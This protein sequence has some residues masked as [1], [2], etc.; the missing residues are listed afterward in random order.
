MYQ[1]KSALVLL[2][3]AA[4]F[5][6]GAAILKRQDQDLVECTFGISTQETFDA[7]EVNLD[8]QFNQ[9]VHHPPE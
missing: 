6:N 8:S 4:T 3:A 7:W 1:L 2:V 9:G 5:A